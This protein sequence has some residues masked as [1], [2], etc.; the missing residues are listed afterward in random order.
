MMRY[1]GC[2][3]PLRVAGLRGGALADAAA[4]LSGAP[5]SDAAIEHLKAL[6]LADAAAAVQMA[7]DGTE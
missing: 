6:A 1:M 2:A 4:A 7:Q 3:K 5:L